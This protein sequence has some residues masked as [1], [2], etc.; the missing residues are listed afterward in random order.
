MVDVWL[1]LRR[2]EQFARLRQVLSALGI[3]NQ[4]IVTNA[5]KAAGQH[6][7]EKPAHELVGSKRH[8]LV[9]STSLGPVVLPAKRYAMLVQCGFTMW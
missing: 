2:N 5:M 8:R 7:K 3:G 1:G 4:P 9:A 6:V